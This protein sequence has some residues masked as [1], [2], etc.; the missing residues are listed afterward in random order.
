MQ[1]DRSAGRALLRSQLRL[2]LRIPVVVAPMFLVSCPQLVV[3]ACR[4]GVIGGFPTLNAR[5]T[6]V[7]ADWLEQIAR[8]TEG[9]APYAANM[10]LDKS[11]KRFDADFE[12]V[13]ERRVPIVIA[14]VGKPD[15]IVEPVHAYGGIVFADVATLRHARNAAAAGADGL[16]LLTAGAGGNTGWQNPFAFVAAVREFF[17]GPLAVAGC[18]SQ[19]LELR[20]LELLGADL[21]YMGTAFL[22]SSESEAPPEH[23]QAILDADIDSIFLTDALS[24]MKANFIRN[25][26]HD[27]G[28]IAADGSVRQTGRIDV[29]SWKEVLSAGQGVGRV[30]AIEPVTVI[31]DRLE[32]EYKSTGC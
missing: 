28:H 20:A 26:L 13:R 9:T 32:R 3:A 6:Q 29:A 12:L 14:S 22:A 2:Q 18:V 21:G 4:S 10:I 15:R 11:N 8:D 27:A 16:V 7:L 31:V 24:G 23:K 30:R 17:D 25:R 5:S 1:L 19:G